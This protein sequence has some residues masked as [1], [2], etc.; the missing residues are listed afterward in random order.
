MTGRVVQVLI[1]V[2]LAGTVAVDEIDAVGRV[3][4][5]MPGKLVDFALEDSGN[6]VKTVW[7]LVEPLPENLEEDEELS[8]EEKESRRQLL[9][10][11]P[12]SDISRTPRMLFRL[13]RDGTGTVVEVRSDL[14]WNSSAIGFADLRDNDREALLLTVP[15]LDGD[16]IFGDLAPG[17]YAWDGDPASPESSLA[18]LL[19]EPFPVWNPKEP[20]TVLGTGLGELRL[21]RFNRESGRFDP[22]GVL[23]MPVDASVR[24]DRITLAAQAVL[25]VEADDQ[26]PLYVTPPRPFGKTRLRSTAIR[27]QAE[28]DDQVVESWA[29]LPQP[30]DL[31]DSHHLVLD[32]GPVLVVQTKTA[33]KLAL[34]GEKRVR[35]YGLD[36][37]RS[38]SGFLP[39]MEGKS[40][41]NLWQEGTPWILDV[42]RDGRSDLVIGYW[43]GLKDSRVVLE[44]FLRKEEGTFEGKPKVTAF[45][46]EN[47][48]RSYVAY[49]R[50]LNGDG[51]F[52]LLVS[53]DE[54]LLLYPGLPSR[55][56]GKL[57]D[58][59]P[60]LILDMDAKD[61]DQEDVVTITVGSDGADAVQ[62][63]ALTSRPHFLDLDGDGDVEIVFVNSG[64]GIRP[65]SFTALYLNKILAGARAR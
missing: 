64:S 31:L 65:G 55:N 57:V 17:L 3:H 34:F 5:A 14:P 4:V 40:G 54:Q 43:K 1:L 50:D 51:L 33:E 38:R 30:E 52:D 2:A 7:F 27:P 9:P 28:G 26:E 32:G 8:E 41:M 59:R 15:P 45:D 22:D 44:V 35:M 53:T 37:D 20:G 62:T 24:Q 23:P 11:C 18:P 58:T 13:D 42:N 16:E 6:G 47:G 56:G 12:A 19:E 25:R 60:E 39:L 10:D 46:V 21:Y 48:D 63:T 61:P 36:P 29:Q 49:G